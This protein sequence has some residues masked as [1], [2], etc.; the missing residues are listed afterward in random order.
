VP[1]FVE[2]LITKAVVAAVGDEPAKK[3]YPAVLTTK[4]LAVPRISTTKPVSE[5]LPLPPLEAGIKIHSLEA[6]E[7]VLKVNVLETDVVLA[8][9]PD[10]VTPLPPVTIPLASFVSAT[11]DVF[12][13][14]ILIVESKPYPANVNEFDTVAPTLESSRLLMTG[15]PIVIV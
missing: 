2:I 15:T 9:L 10:N 13:N 12:T 7:A 14:L 5:Y 3:P 6:V 11:Q 8:L 1:V 4:Y